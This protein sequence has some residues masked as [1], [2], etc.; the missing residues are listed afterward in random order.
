MGCRA[1]PDRD[2]GLAVPGDPAAVVLLQQQQLATRR[3]K[4][5]PR[6]WA[7]FFI[8]SSWLGIARA[9]PPRL[10]TDPNSSTDC[11]LCAVSRGIDERESTH[12]SGRQAVRR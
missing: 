8:G 7:P 5:R 12:E 1:R 9:R 10:L 3:E 2:A 6:M 4:G 11:D